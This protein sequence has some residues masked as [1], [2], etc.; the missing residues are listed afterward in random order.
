LWRVPHEVLL[1]DEQYSEVRRLPTHVCTRSHMPST[2][3]WQRKNTAVVVQASCKQTP[4]VPV[5]V[6]DTAYVADCRSSLDGQV[7]EMPLPTRRRLGEGVERTRR[8]SSAVT[9]LAVS[10]DGLWFCTGG[11]DGWIR[12]W[13]HATTDLVLSLR[14]GPW[15]EGIRFLEWGGPLESRLLVNGIKS[16]LT[17]ESGRCSVWRLPSGTLLCELQVSGCAVQDATW[18]PGGR[19]LCTACSDGLARVWTIQACAAG[20]GPK[21][22]HVMQNHSS[23]LTSVAWCSDGV[24]IATGGEDGRVTVWKTRE[25]RAGHLIAEV[26]FEDCDEQPGSVDAVTCLVWRPCVGVAGRPDGIMLARGGSERRL[27]LWSVPRTGA[28][29]NRSLTDWD[30]VVQSV[31]W[32]HDGR[33]ICTASGLLASTTQTASSEAIGDGVLRIWD[34]VAKK[35]ERTITVASWPQGGAAVRVLA[36]AWSPCGKFIYAATDQPFVRIY[37]VSHGPR[38]RYG[39][40]EYM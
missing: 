26:L 10:P 5:C 6:Q 16:S 17:E 31:A 3:L 15:G 12:V 14:R 2:R 35:L 36:V 37:N 24:H 28:P 30:L 27:D 11:A 39:S 33:M 32:N 8:D 19:Y 13:H 1:F 20:Q 21:I 18:S 25:G 23:A 40:A 29:R 7:V 22:V 9:A 34:V 38:L 4:T